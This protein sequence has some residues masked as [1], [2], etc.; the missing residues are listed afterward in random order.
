[1]NGY[2]VVK[3]QVTGAKRS[4]CVVLSRQHQLQGSASQCRREVQRPTQLPP[5]R[6]SPLT[7][8]PFEEPPQVE[9]VSLYLLPTRSGE[10]E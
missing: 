2:T 3:T 9:T 8:V 6:V 4:A 5:Y 1:M 10:H 7:N